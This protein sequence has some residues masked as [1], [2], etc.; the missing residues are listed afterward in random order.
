V[1][2]TDPS[3]LV[4]LTPSFGSRTR[5]DGRGV[6]AVVRDGAVTRL[7]EGGNSRIP[8]DGYV[9]SGSGDAG[10][11]LERTTAPGGRPAVDLALRAGSERLPPG[12]FEAIVGGGPR[13]V[14]RGRIRVRTVPEGF[15]SAF[16]ARNPRTLAGVT[17]GGELLLV[18]VDG[19]QPR[20]SVGVTLVEAARLM[21]ALG[22]REALNLDGGGS[23]AMVV[24]GKLVNRPSDGAERAVSDALVVLPE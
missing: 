12:S 5:T 15:S 20:R 10:A 7:R 14:K 23:T 3:E 2:C 13:L 11:F 17:R 1:V 22:A 9:L 16:A 21:R 24:G 19:R 18:T 6:E 8:A 4:L